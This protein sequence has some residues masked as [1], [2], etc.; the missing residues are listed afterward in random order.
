MPTRVVP[1]PMLVSNSFL[2]C[3]E[4]AVIVDTGNPGRAGTMLR[5]LRQTGFQP[6]DVSLILLTHGHIDHF[7]AAREL[8]ERTGAPVAI[9][10]LDAPALRSGRNPPLHP[11]RVS[12][13]LLRPFF[14][15][16]HAPPLEPDILL[17]DGASLHEFGIAASVMHTPGHTPGSVSVLAEP[18]ELIAGDLLIGGHLGGHV[19][20]RRPNLPYFLDDLPQTWS[21][22]S[23]I[24]DLPIE[25]VHV[26]HGGPI[27]ADA[28]R[29]WLRNR[30]ESR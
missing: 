7:G 8:K 16:Q 14:Q 5:R 23:R 20:P 1:I 19:L 30:R 10:V 15:H 28:V 13:H 17:Q 4:R 6:A 21:S 26:G 3:G 12:G 24:C 27:Q 9:H 11:S 25:R 2:V 18:D 22:I 29:N